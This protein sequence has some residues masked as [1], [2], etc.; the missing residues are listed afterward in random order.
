MIA[1]DHSAWRFRLVCSL[2][3]FAALTTSVCS[4]Q[5]TAQGRVRAQAACAMCHGLDGIAT[6]PNAA[7]LA[8]QPAVYLAEQLKAYRSGKRSNEVMAVIAKTLSDED[9]RNLSAW[10]AAIKITVEVPQ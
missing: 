2:A 10:Y 1:P 5:D 7:H 8:G 9:I 4:A 6:L 3:A